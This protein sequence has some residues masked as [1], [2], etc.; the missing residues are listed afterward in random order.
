M[1]FRAEQAGIGYGFKF[2]MK[3]EFTDEYDTSVA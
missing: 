2:L 3:E 1:Q